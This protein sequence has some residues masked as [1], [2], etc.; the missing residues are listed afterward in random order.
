MFSIAFLSFFVASFT[1]VF[2]FSSYSVIVVCGILMKSILYC[3]VAL[4]IDKE[5]TV[6][7]HN[8]A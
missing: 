4:P 7:L 3:C 5:F 8:Y 2:T 6:Q 1:H